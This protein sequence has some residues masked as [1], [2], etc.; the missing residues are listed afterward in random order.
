M[1]QDT[2]GQCQGYQVKVHGYAQDGAYAGRRG[3][4]TF[5]TSRRSGQVF[6]RRHY[7]MRAAET[8]RIILR[9]KYGRDAPEV[10]VVPAQDV[11]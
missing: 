9:K 6:R 8:W 10:E 4:A 2:I 11:A 7:A 5:L 3:Q 1:H